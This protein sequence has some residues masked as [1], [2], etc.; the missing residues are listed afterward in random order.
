MRDL[1]QVNT[2]RQVL[3]RDESEKHELIIIEEEQSA[4]LT[5]IIEPD[6]NIDL[7]LLTNIALGLQE[8][9]NQGIFHLNLKPEN[10]LL[11]SPKLIKFTDL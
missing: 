11:I 10:I 9:H 6:W 8:L 7:D 1:K 5:E 2:I 4:N 3:A